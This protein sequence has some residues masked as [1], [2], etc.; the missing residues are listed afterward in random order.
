MV[1]PGT[2]RSGAMSTLSPLGSS[3]RVTATSSV[4][5]AVSK[6]DRGSANTVATFRKTGG[7]VLAGLAST[8]GP[9]GSKR[10]MGRRPE[11]K[12]HHS[13]P[14]EDEDAEERPEPG[15]H[16]RRDSGLGGQQRSV[17]LGADRRIP[18]VVTQVEEGIE[19]GEARQKE[20]QQP[21]TE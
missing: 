1:T 10:G 12:R 2:V 18:Q 16:Q 19:A 8:S 3:A 14:T 17:A 11:P 20:H 15:P 7:R 4:G 21:H 6:T 5:T 13:S 9:G